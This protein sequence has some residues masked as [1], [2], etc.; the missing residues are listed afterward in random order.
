MKGGGANVRAL[1]KE[2]LRLEQKSEKELK[3]ELAEMRI[4]PPSAR[5]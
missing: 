4:D 1:R 2:R 5:S 3:D